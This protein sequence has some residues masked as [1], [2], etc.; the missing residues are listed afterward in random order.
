[1]PD[2]ENEMDILQSVLGSPASQDTRSSSVCD[3]STK[4]SVIT[5]TAERSNKM[6]G[7]SFVDVAAWHAASPG[8]VV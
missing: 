8:R 2:G 6:L 7:R 3:P 1:M 4:K 5:I